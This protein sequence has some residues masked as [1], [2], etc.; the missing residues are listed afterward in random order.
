MIARSDG[1]RRLHYCND[2]CTRKLEE[3]SNSLYLADH[4][5]VATQVDSRPVAE[6]NARSIAM[7]CPC[8]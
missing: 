5:E 1:R 3:I 7:Q 6:M 8:L 2:I 4:L